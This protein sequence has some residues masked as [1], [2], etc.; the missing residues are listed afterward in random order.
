MSDPES[1]VGQVR[2]NVDATESIHVLGCY[3]Y[4]SGGLLYCVSRPFGPGELAR[5]QHDAGLR[6]DGIVGPRTEPL[7][8][9]VN[10]LSHEDILEKYPRLQC[11]ECKGT[12]TSCCNG[13]C[14]KCDGNL[15]MPRSRFE[16][17]A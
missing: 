3:G 9:A 11:D 7:V 4:G 1:F 17:I 6:P 12:G 2:W 16:R 5:L 10:G 8:R 14:H 13:P 15:A